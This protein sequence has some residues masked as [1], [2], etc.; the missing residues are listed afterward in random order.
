ME[1]FFRGLVRRLD[2]DRI[3]WRDDTIIVIDNAP[4]HTS[5]ATISLFKKLRLP[6]CFTGPHSYDASPCEKM[7]AYFKQDDINPNHL[8]MG[9]R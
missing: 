7:F 5:A 9:K 8:P 1:L 3:N 2:K 4:Y 6:L